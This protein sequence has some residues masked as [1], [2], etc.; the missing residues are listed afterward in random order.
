MANL[1]ATI[2]WCKFP[3]AY[4][5]KLDG[6]YNNIIKLFVFVVVISGEISHINSGGNDW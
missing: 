5:N 2:H 6:R 3:A 1:N 4:F